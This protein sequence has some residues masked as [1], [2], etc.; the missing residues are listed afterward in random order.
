MTQA[1]YATARH[2]AVQAAQAPRTLPVVTIGR[3]RN[4]HAAPAYGLTLCGRTWTDEQAPE[5]R[6][7]CARCN[8][9]VTAAPRTLRVRVTLTVTVDRDAWSLAYGTDD[10]ATI[11]DDVRGI[12]RDAVEGGGTFAPDAGIIAADLTDARVYHAP[13]GHNGGRGSWEEID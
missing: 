8:A 11:R 5:A 13:D 1:E 6:V 10:A 12:I 7:T 2:A 4:T 3:G 9:A